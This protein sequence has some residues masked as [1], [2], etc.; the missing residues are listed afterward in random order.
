MKADHRRHLRTAARELEYCRPRQYPIAATL[1][2]S[3]PGCAINADKPA[4]MASRSKVVSAIALPSRGSD[5]IHRQHL[6][7]TNIIGA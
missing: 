4:V 7:V 2:A 1:P 5:R 6:A 3:T